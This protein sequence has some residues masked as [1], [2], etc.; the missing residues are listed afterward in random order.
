MVYFIQEEKTV[1]VS[2]RQTKRL[3]QQPT[4]ACSLGNGDGGKMPS[5]ESYLHSE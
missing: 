1:G 4:R 5:Q 3:L 2:G